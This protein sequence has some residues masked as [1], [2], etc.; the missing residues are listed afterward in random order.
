[1]DFRVVGRAYVVKDFGFALVKS[2]KFFRCG[3]FHNLVGRFRDFMFVFI[4]FEFH[5]HFA[6][7][8]FVI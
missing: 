1:M 4:L 6:P 2:F 3:V 5:F 7:F 8:L